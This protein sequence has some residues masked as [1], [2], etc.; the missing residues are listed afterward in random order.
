MAWNCAKVVAECVG[1][2]VRA[3]HGVKLYDLYSVIDVLDKAHPGVSVR[4]G[5][6]VRGFE[7]EG[8]SPYKVNCSNIGFL[9]T[10][11]ISEDE[12]CP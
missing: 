10:S 3:E 11:Q 5:L 12:C 7:V 6:T 1:Q 8:L 2:T 4:L 9:P